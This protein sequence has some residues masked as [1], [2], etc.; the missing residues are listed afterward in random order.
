MQF[1]LPLRNY[2]SKDIPKNA[3][4]DVCFRKVVPSNT[5]RKITQET[6]KKLTKAV[7]NVSIKPEKE[8]KVLQEEM[9]NMRLIITNLA[10]QI[11]SVMRDKTENSEANKEIEIVKEF[12]PEKTQEKYDLGRNVEN[13]D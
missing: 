13:I 10:K 12:V 7:A 3:V 9:D 5:Q 4:E 2:C 6:K 1:N 8:I 11:P